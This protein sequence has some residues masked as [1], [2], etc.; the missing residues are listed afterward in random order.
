MF[1]E[2]GW[3]ELT[4]DVKARI[5]LKLTD[6]WWQRVGA[7]EPTTIERSKK[8]FAVINERFRD[9]CAAAA[10]PGLAGI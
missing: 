10:T 9:L 8:L 1:T 2:N 4:H 6:L 3:G 5:V 7:P